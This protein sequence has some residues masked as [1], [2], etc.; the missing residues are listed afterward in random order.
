MSSEPR[1]DAGPCVLR[2]F[3]AGDEEAIAH[4]ANNPKV[5]ANLRDH[6]PHPYTLDDAE[7]WVRIANEPD[8][9]TNFAITL[10]DAVVGGIGLVLRTNV[11][12][13]GAEVGYWL[14]EEAWGRGLATAALR[15]LCPYA[16]ETFALRRIDAGV[17][18]TNLASMRVLEK[19]GFQREGVLRKCAIK[20]GVVLD[21]VMYGHVR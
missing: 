6:F 16:F 18:E 8:P 10:D 20:N 7:Q 15:A 1:I 3:R 11:E 12:R 9:S 17:F 14:G 5:A 2:P 4:H 13:I 21:V 19:A